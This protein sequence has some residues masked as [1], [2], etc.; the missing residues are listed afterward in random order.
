MKYNVKILGYSIGITNDINIAMEWYHSSS[1]S[2]RDK[3]ILIMSI[4]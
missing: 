2:P 3:T 1:T 4:R